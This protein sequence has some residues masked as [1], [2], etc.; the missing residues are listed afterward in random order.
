MNNF[1]CPWQN[2]LLIDNFVHSDLH[3]G[4]IFVKFYKP[5]TKFLLWSKWASLFDKYEPDPSS[6]QPA[7]E[8]MSSTD[9]A[10]KLRSLGHDRTAWLQE[11]DRL[12]DHGYRPELVFIDAGLVT[13]LSDKNLKDFVDLFAS[14]ATFDGHRAGRLMVER[15]RSPE[16]VIDP[17]TFA[18]KMQHLILS[19]KSQTFSL[20]TIRISDVLS[21]VLNNVR[22]HHVKL[23][24][25]FVNTVISILLLEGI[26]RQLDPGLDLFKS[27][28]PILRKVGM[29]MNTSAVKG[30]FDLSTYGNIAK[31]MIWVEAR[32]L[33]S[34]AVSEVDQMIKTDM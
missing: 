24:A 33:A 18:L 5:S 8:P 31:M 23:E 17:D 21:E 4:N 20:A 2:M 14:V 12:H 6:V 30:N 25:D 34:V 15:C 27:A 29:Q 7:D 3:P 32:E 1:Y 26:G 9:I 11:L 28:I 13:E 19:V 16:Q 22:S 10:H